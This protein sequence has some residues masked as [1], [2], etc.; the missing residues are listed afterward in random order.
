MPKT[1]SVKKGRK[2]FARPEAVIMG[3]AKMM[4]IITTKVVEEDLATMIATMIVVKVQKAVEV[5]VQ[6]KAVEVQVQQKA[7]EAQVQQKTVKVQFVKKVWHEDEEVGLLKVLKLPLA[8]G[9]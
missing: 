8:D 1:K 3:I 4:T 6:Q 9:N 5:K 2:N 7:V